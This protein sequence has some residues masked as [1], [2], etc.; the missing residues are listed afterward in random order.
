MLFLK[1]KRRNAVEGGGTKELEE[2]A[3]TRFE[4]F[5]HS[6]YC[7]RIPRVGSSVF[8]LD[9]EEIE[10]DL[11]NSRRWMKLRSRTGVN[12]ATVR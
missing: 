9:S 8:Q 3:E 4:A 6:E 10:Q 7:C 5:I 12:D 11:R 1:K 2:R